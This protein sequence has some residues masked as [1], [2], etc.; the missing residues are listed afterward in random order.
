MTTRIVAACAAVLVLAGCSGSEPSAAP[1]SATPPPPTQPYVTTDPCTLL[2]D[3]E[4]SA[5]VGAPVKGAVDD[6]PNVGR[7]CRWEA[8]G[9]EAY[10]SLNLNTPKFP[11]VASARR[12]LDV[13]AKKGSVLADDGLY[14]LIYIDNG[15]PWLQ[16]SSQSAQAG[17][18][19]P[20]PRTYECDRSV[21]LL[22]K[23]V[24]ALKW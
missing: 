21:P 5:H 24:T 20:A 16:F 15:T 14:C 13:G 3:A 18:P 22:R 23:V 19:D 10:V 4:V 6:M 8:P 17:A 9:G 1:P 7:G 11:D 12:T 2:T